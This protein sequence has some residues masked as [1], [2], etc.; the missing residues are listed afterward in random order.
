MLFQHTERSSFIHSLNPMIKFLAIVIAVLALTM[1]FD[2]LP[3]LF[4]T[5]LALFLILA[6]AR[7]PPGR[8]LRSIAP[9]LGLAF[10]L[11]W[12]NAFFARSGGETL[13]AW[14]FLRVTEGSLQTGV[15]LGLR[16]L[17][18][19]LFSFLFAATTDP[20]DL[21]LSMVQQARLPYQMAFGLF[22]GFR[23][24]PFL[25][26]EFEN[27]RAAHRIRGVGERR[28]W[29]GAYRD[30]K[31]FTI[32]LFASV[33]RKASHIGLAMESK[34]FGAYDERT[35]LIETRVTRRDVAFLLGLILVLAVALYIFT[36]S[37]L[38]THLGP[39]FGT[40]YQRVDR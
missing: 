39:Q 12:V 20:R 36:Q 14:G 13:L 37:G 17:T 28:G 2:P 7:I 27:I 32:P 5:A 33:I 10:G 11:A 6:L 21:A 16:V 15:T 9:F 18:I 19:V 25:S 35:Y 4:M 8:L 26:A 38:I 23:F 1:F 29:R 24:L 34:G 31:R 3:T 30:L 40:P 22:A